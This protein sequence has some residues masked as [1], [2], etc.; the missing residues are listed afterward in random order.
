MKI[1]CIGGGPGGLYLGISMKLRNPEHDIRVVERNRPDDTFGWGVVFSDQT[2]DR[3]QTNDPVSAERILG[4]FAH[5]DDID[6]H[7]RGE[8]IT[9]GG[10][11]FC[12]MGRKQ[13]LRLLQARA[14]E[15]DV[16]LEFECEVEDVSDFPEA[17][18]I[19]AC[20]GLN[21]S[22]RAQHAPHFQPDLDIRANKFTWLGTHKVF[23]AFTFIFEQT[24]HGWIWAHAYKFDPQTSTF[25]IE[26][27]EQ[28][29]RNFGFDRMSPEESVS[30][31]E[32]VFA[33]HLEGHG[34]MSNAKHLRGSAGW[35]NFQRVNCTCW[36]HGNLVLL[37]DAAH[38]AHF[39]IGSGTKLALEDAIDLAD[40]LHQGKPLAQALRDYEERRRLE[41]LRIQSSARNSTEW[42]EQI[43]R[44]LHL[45]PIQFAYSLLTRSQRVSHENLRLRDQ[46]WLGKVETWFAEKATAGR[47]RKRVPP[48]FVPFRVRDLE[49]PNRVVVSPMSMYSAE[50][51][52]PDDFHLVHYGARAQGGAGLLFT[53]M[54]DISPDARITPGCAGIYTDEQVAAWQRIVDFV[55]QKTPTRLALQLGHAGPKG[56]TKRMWEG[57]D[58]PLDFGNWPLFGP[59]AVPYSPANQVPRAMT[60]ADMEAVRDDFVQATERAEAAGFDWLELHCAHGYLLSAFLTPLL[61][62]RTDEY[63]GSLENRRRYPLE[64][65]R[66]MR[67]VWPQHKPMSVR[68]SATDW[69]EGGVDAEESVRIAQAF[70]DAGCDVIDV[71]T[72]QTHPDAKPVFGRMFQTPFADRIRNETG[73]ATMAVG[74]IYETDHVNSILAAGRADLC[75]LARPH[76]SNPYWTLHAAAEQGFAEQPWPA[77]YLSGKTQL[78]RNFARAA[79]QAQAG[80]I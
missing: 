29:W 44:Y 15:L 57:M 69:M 4:N 50:N 6:V 75:C 36:S 25:I 77:Q 20:D 55:H 35:I 7:Y 78:E 43:E 30:T 9:S 72:G 66:A 71:S 8:V 38:T 45:E 47:L 1:V 68:I 49:L 39:S 42:F 80:L 12:G 63:G 3:L 53:E 70:R 2:M 54:T 64:V 56:S 19:V 51:G 21:S 67:A 62:Q 24:E 18:L 5:W 22:I 48:M 31:C 73:M 79:T 13:L 76:L 10:H 59:S 52:V 23:E 65:F 37:G 58:Q 33:R 11:G 27:S 16:R 17:D 34:L 60:R 74:N 32:R 26:C 28:T 14:R 46:D 40:E 61:N 41:V